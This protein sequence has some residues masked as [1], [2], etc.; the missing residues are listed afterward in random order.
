MITQQDIEAK[1]KEL[2]AIRNG[3][4]PCIDMSPIL[5]IEAPEVDM[6]AP[7]VEKSATELM[8]ENIVAEREAE[9][10]YALFQ[11][12]L[13]EGE[14]KRAKSIAWLLWFNFHIDV[15]GLFT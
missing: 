14:I 11:K 6:S 1:M 4:I 10:A 13:E 7:F 2:E 3:Q 12:C 8:T 9:R 15:D 5:K